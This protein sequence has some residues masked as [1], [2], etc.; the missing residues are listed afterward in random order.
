MLYKLIMVHQFKR[1]I[2]PRIFRISMGKVRMVFQMTQMAVSYFYILSLHVYA[3][4]L[5]STK[6]HI[7]T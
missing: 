3:Y 5:V 7:S 1:G 2:V 4:L 6:E